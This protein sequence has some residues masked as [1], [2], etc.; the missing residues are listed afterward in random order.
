LNLSKQTE[1]TRLAQS[2][3]ELTGFKLQLQ[4][5]KQIEYSSKTKFHLIYILNHYENLFQI[6]RQ[7]TILAVRPPSELASLHS[8]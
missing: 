3:L 7:H 1:C 8:R 2:D 4:L 5:E 6:I